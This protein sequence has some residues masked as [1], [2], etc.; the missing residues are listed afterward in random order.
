MNLKFLLLSIITAFFMGSC[1]RSDS[2]SRNVA[3]SKSTGVVQLGDTFLLMR[4]GKPYFIKGAGGESRLKR[5]AEA[6]GNSLRIWDDNDADRILD[7]ARQNGLSVLFGLW[8]E[9]EIDGFDYYNQD[10]VDRQFER[11]RKTVLKYKNHP[12]V[13]MWC[14]GNEWNLRARNIQVYDEINRIAAMIH[15]IDPNHPV[16]TAIGSNRSQ[17]FAVLKDRCPEIDILSINVYGEMFRLEERLQTGGWTGPYLI[18]EFGPLGHWE[19]ENTEWKA[20]IEPFS[21]QKSEFIRSIYRKFIG[22]RPPACLGSYVFLWGVKEEGTHTWYSF[23][24]NAGRETEL[25]ETMQELWTG[26]APAN[27]APRIE[28]V[29]VDGQESP[30]WTWEARDQIH[31]AEV[32]GFDPDGDTLTYLWEIRPQARQRLDY[33]YH[34]TPLVPMD[35]LIESARAPK[36]RFRLPRSAGEYRLFVYVFDPRRHVGTANIPF[37]VTASVPNP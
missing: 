6:G 2:S 14:V 24:D 22:S 4:N 32:S 8:I 37:Q 3:G 7:Q 18:S 27:K 26:K 23:F 36:I 25:V 28:K 19:S 33:D 35:G 34:D 29:L 5:L 11:I 17:T 12:A 20:P 1:N 13:L 21:H 15:E 30:S 10:A 9:R 31:T 16:T